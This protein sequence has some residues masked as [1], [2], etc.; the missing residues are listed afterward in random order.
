[1][2]KLGIIEDDSHIRAG[3][4]R[5][6]SLQ[7]DMVCVIAADS[8]ENFFSQL[9]KTDQL[10]VVLS[11]IGLPGQSGIEGI[12]LIKA[13]FPEVQILI[14]T[15]YAD[16]EKIFNALCAG[17]NGYLLKNTPLPKVKEAVKNVFEGDAAMSPSIARKVIAHFQPQAKTSKE[18]LTAREKEIVQAI[19]DGLSYKMVAA[20]LGISFETVKQHI[21]N[22]YKKLQ[23]NS[24]AELI[25]K[26]FKGEL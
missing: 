8:I 19:V 21:K 20:Q 1:M 14:I 13:R 3:F 12:P 26:S 9:T 6:F 25:S 17:A 24:K 15:V 7:Q 16:Q 5:F 10:D 4:E 2:I 23:I 18:H 22:I 11:D